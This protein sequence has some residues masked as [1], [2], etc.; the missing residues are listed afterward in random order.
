MYNNQ[1]PQPEPNYEVTVSYA[2]S[3]GDEVTT[4]AS[5]ES[6]GPA[7]TMDPK[8]VLKVISEIWI[9]LSL[10]FTTTIFLLIKCEWQLHSVIVCKFYL[11]YKLFY[12]NF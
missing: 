9:V 10:I 11:I 3:V 5:L 12:Q 7:A 1:S 2:A 8:Y 4:E 6:S